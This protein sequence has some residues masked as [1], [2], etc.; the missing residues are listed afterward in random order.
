MIKNKE[1]YKITG[2]IE[3]DFGSTITNPVVKIATSPVGLE[4][5]GEL[6][7]EYNVYFSEVEYLAGKY[8]FKA[9]DSVNEKRLTNFSYPIANVPNFSWQTYK[10]EQRTII[11]DTFGIDVANVVLVEEV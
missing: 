9:W 4:S 3:S 1:Y 6:Q 7:C 2:T 5:T 10:E 8:F 11:A